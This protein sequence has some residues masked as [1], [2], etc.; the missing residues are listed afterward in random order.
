[1]ESALS[2]REIQA[3]IR[4]GATL[5]EVAKEAGVDK[6]RIAAFVGPVMAERE[7][8]ARQ[9]LAGTVRMRGE[10]G[11]HRR[12]GRL[13]KERLQARR[14]DADLIS[15]DASRQADLRWRVV[16]VLSSEREPEPRTAEF[17]YDPRGRFNL[18][19]NADARWMIGEELIG[20][21]N[22]DD[23]KTV[24]LRDELAIVRAISTS[25]EA[26]AALP[27]DEIPTAATLYEPNEDTSQL[28]ELYDLLSGISEDSVRIYVGMAD[29]SSPT[30]AATDDASHNDEARPHQAP[31]ADSAPP[32]EPQAQPV[33]ADIPAEDIPAEEQT[34]TPVQQPPEPEVREQ[35]ALIDSP[36]PDPA[37]KPAAKRRRAQVP[38]WDEIMFGAPRAPKDS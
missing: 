29:A 15:W 26:P 9:A 1:M 23:E 14:I 19:D 13:I 33:T 30:P 35:A 3:R 28:D 22:P 7:H 11:S 36:E 32:S 12:L 38:S 24:D 6:E 8:M 5:D 34:E 37:P 25:D 27:G 2:P 4:A 18:A 10:S 31:E 16:G 21:Q 20:S 17:I